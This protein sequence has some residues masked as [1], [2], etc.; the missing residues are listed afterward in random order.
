[1]KYGSF[2]IQ[3]GLYLFG[4]EFLNR[5]FIGF[6]ANAFSSFISCCYQQRNPISGSKM[7]MEMNSDLLIFARIF[8]N[9]FR[10]VSKKTLATRE[11]SR[12]CGAKHLAAFFTVVCEDHPVTSMDQCIRTAYIP[13]WEKD[14]QCKRH[15]DE[16]SRKNFVWFRLSTLSNSV[17][18]V[19]TLTRFNASFLFIRQSGSF[20]STSVVKNV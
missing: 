2:C 16:T 17:E 20:P 10:N 11:T 19:E 7:R 6:L 3:W 13:S 4:E 5:F 15:D 12:G 18:F 1:M 14:G 9:E 8:F